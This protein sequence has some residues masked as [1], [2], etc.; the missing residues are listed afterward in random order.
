MAVIHIN[1]TAMKNKLFNTTILSAALMVMLAGNA[2]AKP[3]KPTSKTPATRK[4]KMSKNALANM[5]LNNV[6][7]GFNKPSFSPAYQAELDRVVKLMADNNAAVKLGGYADSKGTY[8]YNWMLSKK[9]VESVKA[10]M[11]NQGADSSRIA[12]TEY[13]DTK[14]IASNKT[15]DGRRKNRRVEIHFVN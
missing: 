11:V 6:Q 4:Y 7:F 14:P 12:A 10:Y 9:R 15:V 3:G 1:I 5:R 13:G 2:L 8:L